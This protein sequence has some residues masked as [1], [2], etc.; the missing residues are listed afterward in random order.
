MMAS[1]SRPVQSPALITLKPEAVISGRVTRN[2]APVPDILVAATGSGARNRTDADGRYRLRGLSAGEYTIVALTPEDAVAEPIRGVEVATGEHLGRMDLELIEGG[3]VEG[4]VTVGET[5]E[6][7]SDHVFFGGY[8]TWGI[9]DGNGHYRTHVLPGKTRIRWQG[10]PRYA[11]HEEQPHDYLVEVEAGETVSGLDF[12]LVR[13]PMLTGTVVDADGGPVEGA[14]VSLMRGAHMVC[15]A[16]TGPDGSFEMEA[17][18]RRQGY[19]YALW[20]QGGDRVGVEPV[21]EEG[22]DRPLVMDTGGHCILTAL[23]RGG[24]PL[25]GVEFEV[26]IGG[27]WR[28]MGA[29]PIEAGMEAGGEAGTVREPTF[30]CAAPGEWRTA[31]DG[32]VR[33]GPLPAGVELS[34]QPEI[35]WRRRA[36]GD[37]SRGRKL[38][39][40]PG[41]EPIL[42]ASHF[43][44]QGRR[45]V[46]RVID[47][48][49][50]P[51]EGAWVTTEATFDGAIRTVRA[52]ADA[53]FAL[54]RLLT[55]DERGETAVGVL[56]FAPDGGAARATTCYPNAGPVTIELEPGGGATG[57]L[58]GPDGTPLAG[59][60]IEVRAYEFRQ[61]VEIPGALGLRARTTADADGRWMVDRL[62]PGLEYRVKVGAPG[63]RG[64]DEFVLTQGDTVVG[65]QIDVEP[66]EG[67]PGAGG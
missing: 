42:E 61:Q 43:A 44:P 28:G 19:R 62:V 48:D 30:S 55:R 22:L 29:P 8:G 15:E 18:D 49:S 26:W 14:R 31:A 58:T 13:R 35:S 56:A 47:G 32:T 50:E 12:V 11:D 63:F 27:E 52:D 67:P 23:D 65:M 3:I 4:T 66:F 20:A 24:R 17:P 64:S 60:E 1:Q 59:A 53:S 45:L 34:V 33:I 5:G 37:W 57:R 25:E 39:L 51:V 41:D 38:T 10:D 40:L 6:P 7:V 54:D 21:D 2:G 36:I 9:T 16:V 46:G